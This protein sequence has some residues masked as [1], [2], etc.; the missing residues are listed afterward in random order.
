MPSKK[1]FFYLCMYKM[2]LISAEGY[3]NAGVYSLRVQK[4]G[5]IWSGIGVKNIFHLVLKEIH[6]VLETKNP[7]KKQ[8][9]KCKMTEREIFEKFDNLSKDKLNTRSNKKFYVKNDV[10]TTVIKRCR[11]E[12]KQAKEK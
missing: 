12:K 9:K 7:T 6:S 8:I 2:Y 3:I 11:G 1:T 4:A 10:M 5:E